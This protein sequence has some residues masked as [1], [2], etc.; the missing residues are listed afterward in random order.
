[1]AVQ[2][3]LDDDMAIAAGDPDETDGLLAYLQTLC[4]VAHAPGESHWCTPGHNRGRALERSTPGL[5]AV[6]RRRA[7]MPGSAGNAGAPR[8]AVLRGG[9]RSWWGLSHHSLDQV[10]A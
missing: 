8:I 5:S 4:R 1:M 6:G 3:V 7:A 2:G 10:E 9:A